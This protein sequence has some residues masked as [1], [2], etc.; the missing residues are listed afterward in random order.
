MTIALFPLAQGDYN[1]VEFGAKA[2]GVTDSTKAILSAWA[3]AC[4]SAQPATVYIP[5]G[6]YLL[7]QTI[8]SGPCKNPKITIQVKGTLVAPA[9]YAKLGSSGQWL[10]FE[11]VAGVSIY[12]G[13]LDGRGSGLWACKASKG[14]CPYGA[15][16]LTFNNAKDIVI[17]GLT[18][19]NSQLFHIVIDGCR[20]VMI[21]GVKVTAPGNS[22]NTDGIHVEQSTGVT[23]TG[24]SIKTGDDCISIGQGTSNLWIEQITCG[25]G[26]GIR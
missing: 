21:Q 3:K 16:S 6:S 25:P 26:H 24:T 20:N 10:V 14:N 19:M 17:N 7:S 1:V 23:I 15:R 22:P 11:N 8:F 2:D 18:S 13:T 5:P 4:A 9:N 12:G